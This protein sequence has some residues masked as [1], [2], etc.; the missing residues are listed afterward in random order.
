MTLFCCNSPRLA[1]SPFTHETDARGTRALQKGL[2]AIDERRLFG[3]R[4][5]CDGSLSTATASEV[6]TPDVNDYILY[7]PPSKGWNRMKKRKR[8]KKR[9]LPNRCQPL[10]I[11]QWHHG[12]L[13]TR[14]FIQNDNIINFA[15]KCEI[16][17]L[18]KI[19]KEMV[20]KWNV[21]AH[22]NF[23][24]FI[25]FILSYLIKCAII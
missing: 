5:E 13:L 21:N 6:P 8:N 2:N 9:K 12:S 3:E 7:I 4:F 15:N 20:P 14:S 18:R 1:S 22:S 10:Y 11:S 16:N 17:Y 23:F 19:K 24:F 25:T